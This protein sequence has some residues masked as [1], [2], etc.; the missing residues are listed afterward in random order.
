[1]YIA[2]LYTSLISNFPFRFNFII[3]M[4]PAVYALGESRP[5]S[6]LAPSD[7][8]VEILV[9]EFPSRRWSIYTE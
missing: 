3:C 7:P 2:F 4:L 1:M 9:G 8:M 5:A 6:H